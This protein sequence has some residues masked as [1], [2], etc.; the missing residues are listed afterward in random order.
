[1][2]LKSKG[3]IT[4][5]QKEILLIFSKLPDSEMFYLTGKTALAEFF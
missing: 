1:L 4:D 3:I 2:L 5:L